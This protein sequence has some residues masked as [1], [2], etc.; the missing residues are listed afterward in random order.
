MRPSV[1]QHARSGAT[2]LL[3]ATVACLAGCQHESEPEHKTD[4]SDKTVLDG[5][6]LSAARRVGLESAVDALQRGD[7]Q[8]LKMLR[9]WALG[10]AQVVLFSDQDLG[11]LDLGISCLDGTLAPSDR[12]A[13]VARLGSGQLREPARDLCLPDQE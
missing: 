8:R 3:F 7:L 5:M 4:K 13:A 10:R 2:L 1:Q 11:S 9:Q 12:R 6:Q